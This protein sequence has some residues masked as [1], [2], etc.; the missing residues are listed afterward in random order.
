[1]VSA[2]DLP[3]YCFPGIL[4]RQPCLCYLT[5]CSSRVSRH[6]HC[7]TQLVFFLT[8]ESNC[9][10][11][12]QKTRPQRA[13]RNSYLLKTDGCGNPNL[14]LHPHEIMMTSGSTFS[15]NLCVLDVLLPWC[16]AK[17]TVLLRLSPASAVA[18]SRDGVDL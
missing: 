6:S 5:T 17:S 10:G 8:S 16:G 15:M 4:F 12:K 11:R 13:R 1:M 2:H 14:L 7:H 9:D 18:N 3:S